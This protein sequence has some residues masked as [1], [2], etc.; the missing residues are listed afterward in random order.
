M[1]LFKRRPLCFFCLLFLATS[2]LIINISF[3][4]KLL[5]CLFIGGAILLF[6]AIG[7]IVKKARGGTL[8]VI[9]CLLGILLSLFNSA[10]RIDRQKQKAGELVG[11]REISASV[12]DVEY[13][14]ENSAAYTVRL[15][16]ISAEKT[17]IKALLVCAF[18]CE[19]DVGDMVFA[20]AEIMNISDTAMGRSGADI[21]NDKDT[22]LMAVIYEPSNGTVQRFNRELP[23]FSRL[24]V[25]NGFSV[26]VDQMKDVVRERTY[27]FVGED[28][29]AIVNGFLI[30][31]TSDI[32]TSVIRDFRRTGVSHLFAVSGMHI[33]ILLGS[34]ELVLRKLLAHKYIRCAVV[35]VLAFVLL[36]FT[37]FS[38]SALRSVLMLWLV[39]LVFLFSE[40][41]DSPTTLFVSITLILLIFPYAVYELG[42]WMSFLATLGLVTI[43]PMIDEAIPKKTMGKPVLRPL[44]YIGRAALMVSIMTVISN[45]F[46]LPIQ[47]GIFGEISAVAI[48][49]NILLSPLNI[50][51]LISSVICLAFGSI[52]LIGGAINMSVRAVCGI[53]LKIVELFSSADTATVSLKYEF[54]TPLV[55]VFT[56]AMITVMTV[57]LRKKWLVAVPFAGFIL[58]FS[59]GIIIFNLVT[60][61]SLTY[62]GENNK[63]VITITDG[64]DLCVVDMS[65][66][67][68]ERLY[69]A[70]EDAS[71]YGATDVDTFI[72][73][74]VSKGHISSM[75][76]F[77]RSRIVRKIYIP[78]PEDISQ[79]ESS[80]KLAELARNCGVDA[81][82]Y[83]STDVFTVGET[84]VLVISE[85]DDGK[86]SVSVF[87]D[88]EENIF[89]YTD[90]FCKHAAVNG[91]LAECDTVLIGN[92]GIPDKKYSFDVREKTTLIYSSKE[93]AGMGRISSDAEK[94]FIN[95]YDRVV[96]KFRFK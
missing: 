24:F 35:S 74:T 90:A 76:Y 7:L 96:I 23:L 59:V 63:E 64:S 17:D 72:F 5:I 46:L 85:Y 41:A 88:G 69:T 52:P 92:N 86:N 65:N 44:F 30:G 60:P 1:G 91:L 25:K 84:S 2:A 34:V 66:G 49:T 26:A 43:Y 61:R 87:V 83:E 11:S 50:F 54:V 21:T 68:Y 81:Q 18:G 82:L 70:F 62:Y 36:L 93:L 40:E 73:T 3:N 42:M 55:M 33:S 20:Y 13:I 32:P 94:T 47:W 28:T 56:V 45:V 57:R 75:E 9:L 27:S 37:G 22:L 6:A 29:G 10:F 48:P 8:A 38:I 71:Q 4:E 12:T 77:F 14:S 19:L 79:Y 31:D 39:Y 58:S 78:V 67:S 95:P 80:Y 53:I 89:G 15:E 51:L 16:E